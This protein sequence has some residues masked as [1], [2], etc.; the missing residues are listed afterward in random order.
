MSKRQQGAVARKGRYQGCCCD[1]PVFV[2]PR[3]A[4]AEAPP[5]NRT[6]GGCPHSLG[7][8]EFAGNAGVPPA[9]FPLL[10][11]P[12]HSAAANAVIEQPGGR[13]TVRGEWVVEALAG[14]EGGPNVEGGGCVPVQTQ[15]GAHRGPKPSAAFN[16]AD[17]SIDS[18]SES[19]A[20]GGQPTP[21]PQVLFRKQ[22]VPRKTAYRCRMKHPEP[23]VYAHRKQSR[24]EGGCG[25][26]QGKPKAE[27]GFGRGALWKMPR[28][29]TRHIRRRNG[30]RPKRASPYR[31]YLPPTRAREEAENEYT[32]HGANIIG[33]AAISRIAHG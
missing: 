4:Q 25:R 16:A 15:S 14:A 27:T 1:F 19:P 28:S 2:F 23:A 20:G 18:Q 32:N 10:N 6:A 7:E 31:N 3:H 9:G 11:I 8:G 22:P 5:K 17:I 24:A 30:R 21:E 13:K 33:R 26:A 29:L 12:H